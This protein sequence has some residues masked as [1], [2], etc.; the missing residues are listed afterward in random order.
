MD[1]SS[2]KKILISGGTGFIGRQL[3]KKLKDKGY[4]VSILSRKNSAGDDIPAYFW[5]PEKGLM[6]RQALRDVTCIVHLA[7]APVFDRKWT[8]KRKKILTQSR[9]HSINFLYKEVLANETKLEAFISASAVGYYGA[10]TSGHVFTESDPPAPDFLGKLCDA[11]EKAGEQFR[12]PGARI[13]IIRTG[14]VLAGRSSI[15]QKI[16]LPF[17]LGL[18]TIPGKGDQYLPWIHIDDL[19]E[20]Y[21]RAIEDRQMNGVYNAVSPDSRTMKEFVHFLADLLKK[22][23]WLPPVPSWL[24]KLVLGERS[25]MVLQGSRISSDKIRQAGFRFIFP[26]LREALIS[27]L[28]RHRSA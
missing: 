26:D 20:I 18:G 7:G 8:R 10:L 3:C 9:T 6:D 12:A 23:I 2:S 19:C 22:K 4:S 1:H 27:I 14:L 5:D 11:W 16:E 15:L 13:V 17:R 25:G 28:L 21:I 24:I